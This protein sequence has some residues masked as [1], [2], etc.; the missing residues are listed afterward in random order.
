LIKFSPRGDAIFTKIKNK[1]NPHISG[2][3]NL[4]PT[5]WTVRA[6]SLQSIRENYI[7][8]AETWRKLQLLLN[9]PK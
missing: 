8:L 2:L 3:R 1:I 5:R 4:C 9:S 6:A 7:A